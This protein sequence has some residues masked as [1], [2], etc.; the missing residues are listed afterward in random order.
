MP[1]EI[2]ELI[3]KDC[4]GSSAYSRIYSD[5]DQQQGFCDFCREASDALGDIEVLSEA[6]ESIMAL[7]K[8]SGS[9]EHDARKIED[10]LAQDWGMFNSEMSSEEKNKILCS[11]LKFSKVELVSGQLYVPK[12][13]EAHI[14]IAPS[15]AWA[16]LSD[17]LRF[18]N[19]FF[20]SNF[21]GEA[22]VAMAKALALSSK[23]L[24]SGQF[25][26]RARLL[27]ENQN[28][29]LKDM[30]APP[31]EKAKS[32][33]AN[34][35]GLPHLYAA[36]DATTS[37]IESRAGIRQYLNVAKM[38]LKY[39]ITCVDLSDFSS[40]N[41]FDY[42]QDDSEAILEILAKRR[43][44]VDLGKALSAP[45]R[46]EDD[47]LTYVPTQFLCEFVKSQNYSAVIFSSSLNKSGKN[48]VVFDLGCFNIQDSSDI[49]KYEMTAEGW[50][51]T[52][53]NY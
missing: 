5:Y 36:F 29:G 9:E 50:T 48:L 47:L 12:Y 35:Q 3:C 30:G 10:C 23:I 21:E 16:D 39:D 13:A 19:R 17:E 2:F 31:P 22:R 41:L 37:A 14:S 45:M 52:L 1:S 8:T 32:G 51:P 34:P 49:Q 4:I 26:Y 40:I 27:Q 46:H 6:V 33:R 25:V 7:Y 11:A 38:V 44:L 24:S 20:P 53:V 28:F 42:F 15:K 18:R 43:L